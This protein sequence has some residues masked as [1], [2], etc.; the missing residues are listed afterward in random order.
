MSISS[1]LK[2]RPDKVAEVLCVCVCVCVCA[3]VHVRRQAHYHK[4]EVAVL[5]LKAA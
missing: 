3:C 1:T 2:M 5:L 4:K